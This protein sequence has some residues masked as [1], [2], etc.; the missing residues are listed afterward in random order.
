MV[1]GVLLTP[2]K[3]IGEPSSRFI[4]DEV[5]IV[6]G[7]KPLPLLNAKLFRDLIH[8]SEGDD[9][10]DEVTK[11]V[12]SRTGLDL[13]QIE[14]AVFFIDSKS[15]KEIKATQEKALENL[16]QMNGL[17]EIGLAMHVFH[18]ANNSFPDD[19]GHGDSKVT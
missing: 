5:V 12:A 8:E 4:P 16:R 13:T 3:E 19:D 10:L 7:I 2:A 9:V 15:M 18:D 6:A 1:Q 17:R 11:A 14:E